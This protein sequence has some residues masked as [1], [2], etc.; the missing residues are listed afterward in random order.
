MELY[1]A[2]TFT[3]PFLFTGGIEGPACDR[4]GNIYAVNYSTQGTIG[5][6]S[7]EGQGRVF[8]ELPGGSVGNEIRFGSRGEM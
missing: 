7:P 5:I 1:Q 2:Q 3:A 6:V 4:A 8:I